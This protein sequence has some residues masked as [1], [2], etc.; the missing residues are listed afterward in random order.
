MN[1]IHNVFVWFISGSSEIWI[2]YNIPRLKN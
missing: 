1:G 2:Y